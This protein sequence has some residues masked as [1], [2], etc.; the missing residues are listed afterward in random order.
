MKKLPIGLQEY[1]DLIEE[2]CVYVDKTKDIISLTQSRTPVFFSRPRRFGKSLLTNTI[3]ELF[4]GSKL[5]KKVGKGKD[6]VVLI[7]EYDTPVLDNIHNEE[8]RHSFNRLILSNTY[9]VQD[10]DLLGVKYALLKALDNAVIHTGSAKIPFVVIQAL[11][12]VQVIR[13]CGDMKI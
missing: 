12:M 8:V 11:P 7:D 6:V 4:L 10:S 5:I 13:H 2:N 9:D 1:R 3:K